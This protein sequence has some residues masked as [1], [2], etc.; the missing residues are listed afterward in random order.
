M[1][2]QPLLRIR[3]PNFHFEVRGPFA[4]P[5]GNTERAGTTRPKAF[6][7][8]IGTEEVEVECRRSDGTFG[9]WTPGEE[10]PSFFEQCIYRV[11]A[12]SPR[13]GE[14]P[15]CL[16]RDPLFFESVLPIDGTSIRAGTVSFDRQVGRS[17][18]ELTAKSARLSVT[19]EVFPTKLDYATDFKDL[20][21]DLD[22]TARGLALDF[23]TSTYQLGRARPS[24]E[25]RNIEWAHLLR[26]VL[27]SVRS[28]VHYIDEHPVHLLSR[29][30]DLVRAEKAR[31]P[32]ASLHVSLSRGRGSGSWLQVR[33]IQMRA[34]VP[35]HRAQ[36]ISDTPEHRWIASGLRAIRARCVALANSIRNE[37]NDERSRN[38]RSAARLTAAATELLHAAETLD[39]LLSLRLFRDVGEARE[40]AF[41]SLTLQSAPGYQEAC[42]GIV[43]LRSAIGVGPG[44]T[45]YSTKQVSELYELW[46]YVR[47]V[48]LVLEVSGAGI[49]ANDVV[50]VD[51]S[52]FRVRLKR[53]ERSLVRVVTAHRTVELTYN[54]SFP[55]IT[56]DQ[57]P[58]VLLR[59]RTPGMPDIIVLFDAKYRLDASA[60]YLSSFGHPGPPLDAIN[61]LHRYRDAIVLGERDAPVGRPVVKGVALFP[62]NGNEEDFRDHRLHRSLEVLGVGAIPFLPGHTDIARA[63]LQRL[64]TMPLSELADAGPPFLAREALRAR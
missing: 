29:E 14:P 26:N 46:C 51:T 21:R 37:L 6:L 17:L 39:Q 52:G 54:E 13:G 43:A 64:L 18:L 58:D 3:S 1:S 15:R 25:P 34:Q 9:R 16:H 50:A 12:V 27:G 57:R 41:S 30:E 61:A 20:L 31:R 45:Q 24:T 5:K 56:G 44:E 40:W 32:S 22:V 63:W 11:S 53:G 42:R 60:E 36:E 4:N 49:A 28:A 2:E 35:S 55:G 48:G 7:S 62:F 23:L 10:G 8:V 38:R 47:L 33:G 59:F 19:V